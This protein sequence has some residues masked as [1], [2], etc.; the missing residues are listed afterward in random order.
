[1]RGEPEVEYTEVLASH[2]HYSN[3]RITIL[4]V[5]AALFVGLVAVA[6]GA[7]DILPQPGLLR[8]AQ[9]FLLFLSVV[10]WALE[11]GVDGYL[12]AFSRRIAELERSLQYRHLTSRPTWTIWVALPATRAPYLLG[13]LLSLAFLFGGGV[14]YDSDSP[15]MNDGH[16]IQ[17]HGGDRSSPEPAR[18]EPLSATVFLNWIDEVNNG[19][20]THKWPNYLNSHERS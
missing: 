12:R 6:T 19:S 15:E 8:A 20:T 14:P 17:P 13:V 3:L 10:F 11:E 2:R 9:W 4:G 18:P 1:M 7:A 5:F 16:A